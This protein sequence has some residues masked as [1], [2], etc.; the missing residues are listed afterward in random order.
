MARELETKI[1]FTTDDSQKQKALKAYGQLVKAQKNVSKEALASGKSFKSTAKELDIIGKDI[2]DVTKALDAMDGKWRDN[3]DGAETLE[4]QIKRL[5]D[6]FDETSQKVGSF[7]DIQSNLGASGALIGAAGFGG[8][9]RA[10]TLGGE[11]AALLEEL[12]RL[13]D[14]FK[15]AGPAIQVTAESLGLAGT[16]GQ[17]ASLGLGATAAS[18]AALALPLV[19][20]AGAALAVVAAFK[21]FN[22][23]AE[24]QNKLLLAQIDAQ[25]AVNQ[26]IAE[27][28]TS[29]EAQTRLDE[30]QKQREQEV[31]LLNQQT[32]AY[33]S[34]EDQLGIL[35]GAVQLFDSREQSLADGIDDTRAN[36]TAMDAE[37]RQLESALAGG[38]LATNDAAESEANLVEERKTATEET[39]RLAATV[40]SFEARRAQLLETRAVAD[41]N[42]LE[43]ETLASKFAREDDLLQEKEHR[44]NLADI[45]S[46][47]RDKIE[48]IGDEL[49]ELP[50]ERLEK[51][52]DV[53][54]K[55][56]D[57]LGKL[58]ND[59]FGKSRAKLA[60]F[61]KAT[62]KIE[63]AGTKKRLRAAIDAQQALDDAER[64]NDVLA[65]LKA[66]RD[67][68]KQLSR[69]LEDEQDAEQSRV[70]NFIDA[71]QKERDAFNAKQA[72]IN[73]AIQAERQAVNESLDERRAKLLEVLSVQRATNDAAIDAENERFDAQEENQARQADRQERRQ[74]LRDSQQERAHQKQL[75]QIQAEINTAS[76]AHQASLA[77]I[78]EIGRA[79]QS[80]RPPASAPSRQTSGRA[81]SRQAGGLLGG[82]LGAAR[83]FGSRRANTGSSGRAGFSAFH[84]GGDIDFKGGQKEGF[85]FVRENERVL[86]PEQIGSPIPFQNNQGSGITAR[87]QSQRP[88][89]VFAPTIQSTVGDIASLA[90]VTRANEE[91]MLEFGQQFVSMIERRTVPI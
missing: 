47:G 7:G 81:G 35:T 89:I 8:A 30:L 77:H 41:K 69:G 63:S 61:Q 50:R 9:E 6:T 62:A 66:Q 58:R 21:Q 42:A 76:E 23:E 10:L 52:G 5:N 14:A 29:D 18:L 24:K 44:A 48:A 86:T 72:E 40:A 55:G 60:D 34:M 20:V 85:I 68:E 88:Q 71:Q 91:L 65:F 84:G 79:I 87:S 45:A 74:A 70:Q 38:T 82:L 43:N 59:F 17:F 16:A 1:V 15:A 4:Q 51:L 36:V 13:K 46:E 64:A 57:K 67:S 25:R 19:L 32:D 49:S 28:L 54:S 11:G 37:I 31:V 33:A 3:V 26:A 80:I 90:D 75:A 22:S 83:Q 53:E 73:A 56:N 78:Q 39:D 12:P 27:G 2:R